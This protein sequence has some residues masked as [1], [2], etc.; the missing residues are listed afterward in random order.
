MTR[1][2]KTE[3]RKKRKLKELDKAQELKKKE[4]EKVKGSFSSVSQPISL[5]R[6]GG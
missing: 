3:A 6:I 2:R 4:L 1:K 5:N